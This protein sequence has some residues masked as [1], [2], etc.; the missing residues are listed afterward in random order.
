[1]ATNQI[2]INF[3]LFHKRYDTFYA[4]VLTLEKVPQIAPALLEYLQKIKNEAYSNLQ[5]YLGAAVTK[6]ASEECGSNMLTQPILLIVGILTTLPSMPGNLDVLMCDSL[7]HLTLDLEAVYLRQLKQKDTAVQQSVSKEAKELL[8][9]IE[10][11]L[12]KSKVTIKR[13]WK[14]NVDELLA[15]LKGF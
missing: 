9:E 6:A 7:G 15:M 2:Y 13:Q 8:A 4:H 10:E 12:K 14:K 1:M 3:L 11:R 5:K